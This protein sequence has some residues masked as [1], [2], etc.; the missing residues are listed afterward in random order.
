MCAQILKKVSL[1][2]I[3][4]PQKERVKVTRHLN[5][6]LFSS[7]GALLFLLQIQHSLLYISFLPKQLLEFFP[8]CKFVLMDYF[9]S[10][11]NSSPW[12]Q[13]SCFVLFC[14]LFNFSN[15]LV[16]TLLACRFLVKLFSFSSSSPF[17]FLLLHLLL[18]PSLPPPLP[19]PLPPHFLP[20]PST[21]PPFSSLS[22]LLPSPSLPPLL[23]FPLFFHFSLF[24]LVLTFYMDMY[25]FFQCF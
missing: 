19:L 23:F 5:S 7:P 14:F 1:Y 15:V 21:P 24:L 13:N 10:F 16:D 18:Y 9:S 17:S 12:T 4:L 25:G 3:H 22:L 20:P 6:P 8:R 11:E 2:Y